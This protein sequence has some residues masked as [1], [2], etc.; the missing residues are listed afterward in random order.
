MSKPESIVDSHQHVFWE[1][2]DDAG[3]I[4]DMNAH[5]IAYAWLL[6]WEI[7]PGEMEPSEQIALNP[8]NV[9][10]DGTNAGIRLDDLVKARKRYPDR[11][12]LGYCPDPRVANAA[13]LLRAAA[14]MY[15]VKVCGEWKY[16][17]LLDDPRCLELFRAAGEMDMPVVL[18]LDVPYLPGED[19]EPVYQKRWY[20]GTVE[21]LE[22]V[23]LACPETNFIGHAPGFWREIC[24]DAE[25]EPEMFPDAFVAEGGRLYAFFDR[26]PNLYADL[27]AGS[28]LGALQRD[29]A[30]AVEFLERF[31]DR[32]LFGR[33]CYEQALHR[34][35]QSCNLS[36]QV[37]NKIYFQNAEKL[38]RGVQAEPVARGSLLPFVTP[39]VVIPS[40]IV[41]TYK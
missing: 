40:A 41:K 29:S 8:A 38:V 32:L 12:V 17:M 19:G 18:H 27:S 35:L 21:N 39:Q 31:Q 20:G 23:L 3:L 13:D 26:H 28:G 14:A 24:G 36:K 7:P 30:H 9:R 5:S 6:T 16:R 37:I 1:Q 2:R 25:A 33:D 10:P 22:R 4:A 15:G 34:F 11:F